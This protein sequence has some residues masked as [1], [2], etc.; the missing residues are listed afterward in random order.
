VVRLPRSPASENE[1]IGFLRRRFGA[2]SARL[3]TG[4]GDDAAVLRSQSRE[5][6]IYTADLLLEGIHF[7]RNWIS[8]RELGHKAL[9]VNL[10]DIA[11]MGARPRF[12]LVSLAMP[13]DVSWQWIEE[14]YSGMTGLGGK[15]GALLV[16]GDLS[17]SHGGACLA[18]SLLGETVGKKAVLRSGGQAG[19]ILYVSGILGKAAAG[20]QL[21]QRGLRRGRGALQKA[22]LSAH[23]MP[24]PR[25]DLGLWLS[26]SR[27]ASAMM[28]LSDGLSADLPRLCTE[29]GVGAE[30][31]L[32]RLPTFSA[33]LRWGLDP[34]ALALHGGEDYELLFAV[35]AGR[36]GS[37]EKAYPRSF[38]TITPIGRLV[39]KR[40]VA[41]RIRPAAGPFPLVEKGFDHFKTSRH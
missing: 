7:K 29:S 8:A 13:P 31:D 38:P 32:W 27:F 12:Y 41:C 20:L 26:R 34:E 39:R 16:G 40:G 14:L 1:V 23:R 9:A 2:K 22:A 28:D 17:G 37:L 10:S 25:C 3:P 35:P 36:T 18:I 30:L 4:I 24:Q 21:L 33:A 6:W 15:H 19:D 11:A 5:D